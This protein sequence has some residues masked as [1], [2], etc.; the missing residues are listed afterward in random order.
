MSRWVYTIL[1]IRSYSSTRDLV[2][3]GTDCWDRRPLNHC[4]LATRPRCCISPLNKNLYVFFFVSI[5]S[6]CTITCRRLP[7]ELRYHIS[8]KIITSTG[9]LYLVGCIYL[10]PIRSYPLT[11]DLA[12]IRYGL[13]GSPLIVGLT[14]GVLAIETGSAPHW[15]VCNGLSVQTSKCNSLYLH[16]LRACSVIL[17]VY[18]PCA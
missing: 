11:R 1:P 17:R 5:P 8:S 6:H 14:P 13:L 2:K 7:H 12:K 9:T 15:V 16:S 3:P 4:L 10:L 18:S